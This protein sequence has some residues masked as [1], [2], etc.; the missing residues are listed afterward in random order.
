[1]PHLKNEPLKVL[2]LI[3]ANGWELRHLC[4]WEWPTFCNLLRSGNLPL[5]LALEN[6]PL[7]PWDNS[8]RCSIFWLGWL[9]DVGRYEGVAP[10]MWHSQPDVGEWV[11][12]APSMFLRMTYLLQSSTLWQF[13][14][15]L[16]PG[17]RAPPSPPKS[18]FFPELAKGNL[19]LGGVR[20]PGRTQ[21]ETCPFFSQHQ[22]AFLGIDGA[23]PTHSPTSGWEC[24]IDGATPSYL[25]ISNN[26][27]NQNMPHR[28]ELSQDRR[29]NHQ[30]R[31][32]SYPKR[33]EAKPPGKTSELSFLGHRWHNF[34]HFACKGRDAL[35]PN[36]NKWPEEPFLDGKN[37]SSGHLLKLGFKASRPLL[38]QNNFRHFAKIRLGM[39]T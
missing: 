2:K 24:H 14:T 11:G 21:V 16:G 34:R 4:P 1:M 5:C 13:A 35:K 25:P 22:A 18:G 12:V 37:G 31:H 6:G 9:M 36:F 8:D 15:L 23:T 20:F 7:L 27:P 3:L 33:Q 39:P 30:E 28:S 32:Q 38:A 17:K 10:S 26:Q 29:Q 19:T